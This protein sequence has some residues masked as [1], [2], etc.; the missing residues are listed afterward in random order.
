MG[1]LDRDGRGLMDFEKSVSVL[2]VFLAS[3]GRDEGSLDFY[4]AL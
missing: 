3:T 1:L 4:V 2:I